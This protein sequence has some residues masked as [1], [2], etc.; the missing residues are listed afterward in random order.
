MERRARNIASVPQDADVEDAHFLRRVRHFEQADIFLDD[1]AF[2]DAVGPVDLPSQ[3]WQMELEFK[4]E[5]LKLEFKLTG[6]VLLLFYLNGRLAHQTP[7][8]DVKLRQGAFDSLQ[9]TLAVSLG[10]SLFFDDENKWRT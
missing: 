1:V 9:Q 5:N 3:K 7:G 8:V 10:Q 2:A 6:F 4:W